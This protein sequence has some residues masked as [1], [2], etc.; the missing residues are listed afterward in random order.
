MRLKHTYVLLATILNKAANQLRI[1]RPK[2]EQLA[3]PAT[4]T[5]VYLDIAEKEAKHIDKIV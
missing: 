2:C 1:I 3:F 4:I 5:P